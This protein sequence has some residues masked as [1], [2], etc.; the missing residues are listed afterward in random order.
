[1][2]YFNSEQNGHMSFIASLPRDQVCP[3]GWE[4]KAN[5]D[6]WRTGPYDC[7]CD[8]ALRAATKEGEG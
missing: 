6:K 2:S 7:C 5:C 8:K 1:M 3:C 4:T